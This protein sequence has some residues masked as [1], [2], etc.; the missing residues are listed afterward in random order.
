MTNFLITEL[1]VGNT[2]ASGAKSDS[3]EKASRNRKNAR[4]A[5]DAVLHFLDSAELARLAMPSNSANLLRGHCCSEYD[6][7]GRMRF[8]QRF[9]FSFG[10]PC[11]CREKVS[12]FR[13]SALS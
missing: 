4:K 2:F 5:Y 1:D 8:T 7:L 12:T 10:P 3:E 9:A 6:L 11:S 13:L